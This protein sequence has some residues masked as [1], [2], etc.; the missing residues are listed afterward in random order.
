[1]AMVPAFS[2][3]RWPPGLHWLDLDPFHSMH[4]ALAATVTRPCHDHGPLHACPSI[5]LRAPAPCP[6][7]HGHGMGLGIG[8][9]VKA[10]SS[11]IRN[12]AVR[13]RRRRHRH[14][15][16]GDWLPSIGIGARLLRGL[17]IKAPFAA[18]AG[19]SSRAAHAG[20][21]SCVCA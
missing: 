1:M 2:R 14:R 11:L 12:V 7:P 20:A 18:L 9:Q 5:F 15:H 6:T 16:H 8:S 21:R 19:R 3:R 13:P 4:G 10:T 17:G